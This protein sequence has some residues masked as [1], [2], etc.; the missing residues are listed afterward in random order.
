M[1]IALAKGTQ[2]M[3]WVLQE[4]KELAKMNMRILRKYAELAE[5]FM[6]PD[7]GIRV[8]T[9][10]ELGQQEK[11]E[12]KVHEEMVRREKGARRDPG[13]S[14]GRRNRGARGGKNRGT[15][16]V[17]QEAP[18]QGITSPFLQQFGKL[19]GG[20]KPREEEEEDSMAWWKRQLEGE[21]EEV[22]EEPTRPRSRATNKEVSP[23]KK[24]EKP[25]EDRDLLPEIHGNLLTKKNGQ[26]LAPRPKGVLPQGEVENGFLTR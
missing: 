20:P 17:D 13:L 18:H 1:I 9:M 5:I 22:L 14:R 24:Q 12:W 11:V 8:T 21:E 26:P 2:A 15:R 4:Q 16:S 3:E 25:R 23:S 19:V 7:N 10:L 6:G